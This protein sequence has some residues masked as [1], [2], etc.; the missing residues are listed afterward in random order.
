MK[1][2]IEDFDFYQKRVMV[3]VDFNVPMK[4]GKIL[5]DTRIVEA[6]PTIKFLLGNS[7]KVIL[8]SHLGR[9]DGE[10]KEEFSLKPIFEHLKTLLPTVK[11]S[12][13][14]NFDFEKLKEQTLSMQP[15]EI[16]MLDNIRFL[17]GEEEN[18][19]ALSKNLASLADF[20]VMDAFGTAHRKHCSTYG[21]AKLLPSCMGKLM[22]RE[23]EIFDEALNNPQR[24]LVAVLGGAKIGDKITMTENL[25]SKVN[26]LLIGGGMC[27]TFIKALK[28]NVGK[29]LV[30]DEKLDFCYNVIKSAIKNKV[31]IVLPVD[32]VCAKSLDDYSEVKVLKTSHIEPD[33]MGLDI[34]PKTV[35]LFGKYIK[36][37]RT[38]VWNGPMGAYEFEP[39]EN[40]TKQVA[41]LIAQNKKCKAIVGGGDVVS[42]IKKFDLESGF[43]HISTGGGASLKLLEG[44]TLCAYDVLADADEDK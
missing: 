16:M 27:F 14:T 7:A 1:K 3:R 10:V 37:A 28:G 41:E 20:F 5:N 25:L 39:F 6:L 9:P 38:L 23:I 32:F 22:Q 11:M 26:T 35:K 36:K 18:D 13:S 4:D 8:V 43:Y 17:K 42:A 24:P 33:L 40:G 19:E 12:L 2:T 21:V 34:G 29:S 15:G 30:D 44:K 31:R